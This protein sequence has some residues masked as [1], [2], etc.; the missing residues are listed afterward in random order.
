[1]KYLRVLKKKWSK[2]FESDLENTWEVGVEVLALLH[3]DSGGSVAV[4]V[5][6]VVDVVLSTMSREHQFKKRER[7]IC[8]M[9]IDNTIRARERKAHSHA[10]LKVGSYGNMMVV[11]TIKI[12]GRQNDLMV[13]LLHSPSQ[14]D[15]GKI[16]GD[17]AVVGICCCGV[18]RKRP[19]RIWNLEKLVEQLAGIWNLEKLV[20][21]RLQLQKDQEQKI[22]LGK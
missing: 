9:T 6:Q 1:M 14:S 20:E 13:L 12:G 17:G 7:K 3:V 10:R 18:V 5:Q 15:E 11:N 22:Y 21:Q 8:I 16:W 2:F 19:A 4:A